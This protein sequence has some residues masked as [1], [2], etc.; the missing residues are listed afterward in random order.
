MCEI[1]NKLQNIPPKLIQD[2]NNQVIKNIGGSIISDNVEV[3]N[4]NSYQVWSYDKDK[5]EE[6][7]GAS[8]SSGYL[9]LDTINPNYSI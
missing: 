6:V 2:K 3:I 4:N 5:Q 1:N 7:I 8:K 9:E